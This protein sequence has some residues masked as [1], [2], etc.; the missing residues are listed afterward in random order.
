MV[1]LHMGTSKRRPHHATL[2]PVCPDAPW[3]PHAPGRGPCLCSCLQA[4]GCPLQAPVLLPATILCGELRPPKAPTALAA[5]LFKPCTCAYPF[6]AS[7]LLHR[8]HRAAPPWWTS[9][10]CFGRY[11]RLEHHSLVLFRMSLHLQHAALFH[12][13]REHLGFHGS[14]SRVEWYY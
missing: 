2:R 14:V 13:D 1:V 11:A 7:L 10:V 5:V 12:D 6:S 3:L 4:V 8:R 9:L